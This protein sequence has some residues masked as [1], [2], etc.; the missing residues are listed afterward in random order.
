MNGRITRA[1]DAVVPV[2]DHGFLYGEGV[3][4]TLRTF[5]G[6]PFLF[7]RHMQRLRNSAGMLML[8]V[9][10]YY[11]V[12]KAFAE[13]LRAAGKAPKVV[14]VACMRKLLTILNAMIRD[15]TPWRS[16]VQP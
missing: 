4:E 9:P 7:D 10:M 1:D 16:P 11:P 8:T 15:M 12:I 6:R 3:Y 2:F 14:I 5:G 13:R